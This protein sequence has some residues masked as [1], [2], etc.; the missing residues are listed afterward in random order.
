MMASYY[1][2]EVFVPDTHL[3]GGVAQVQKAIHKLSLNVSENYK[4]LTIGGGSPTGEIVATVRPRG[5]VVI[6]RLAEFVEEHGT[7]Y[8]RLASFELY[9]NTLAGLEI[10]TFDELLARARFIVEVYT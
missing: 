8:E 5:V 10:I 1:R 6:G 2:A 3:R 4:V 7:N 9:R